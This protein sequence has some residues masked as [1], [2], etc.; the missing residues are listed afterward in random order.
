M[1][2]DLVLITGERRSVRVPEAAILT[3]GPNTLV[4]VV[5]GGPPAAA[6]TADGHPGAPGSDR[7]PPAA[8]PGRPNGEQSSDEPAAPLT[9]GRRPVATGARRAGWVEITSG[10]S[11]GE[12]VVVAGLQGLRDGMQVRIARPGADSADN[13]PAGAGS[14]EPAG[15]RP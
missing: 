6:P 12:R 1:F 4:Y 9:V 8:P 11:P 3:R 15:A 7:Q 5:E 14:G 10:V 13:G 2:L